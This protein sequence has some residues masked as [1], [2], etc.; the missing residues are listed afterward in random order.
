MPSNLL[1]QMAVGNLI[2][3]PRDVK[4][5]RREREASMREQ[6]AVRR[7]KA[8]SRQQRRNVPSEIEKAD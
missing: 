6:E 2:R 3:L 1:G 4:A 8:T 7:V 5:A